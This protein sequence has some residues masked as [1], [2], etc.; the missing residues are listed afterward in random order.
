MW[1][2]LFFLHFML[3]GVRLCECLVFVFP[4]KPFWYQFFVYFT[5]VWKNTDKKER[6]RIFFLVEF[7]NDD[8]T[9]FIRLVISNKYKQFL[10]S[11]AFHA[12][13]DIFDW[14]AYSWYIY[15]FASILSLVSIAI[16]LISIH[17]YTHY[18]ILF[19]IWRMFSQIEPILSAQGVL[20]FNLISSFF[21]FL[22]CH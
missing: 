10:Q 14:I 22:Y 11:I 16:H 7:N 2:V 19:Y 15:H 13:I 20:P 6:V 3:S 8:I 1:V 12:Q 18:T 9:D 4:M 21:N 17:I 5:F